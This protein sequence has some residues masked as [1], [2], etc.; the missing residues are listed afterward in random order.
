MEPKPVGTAVNYNFNSWAFRRLKSASAKPACLWQNLSLISGPHPTPYVLKCLLSRFSREDQEG[1]VLAQCVRGE[2]AAGHQGHC[3]CSFSCCLLEPVIH[4]S[5][6]ELHPVQTLWLHCHCRDVTRACFE[7]KEC[8]DDVLSLNWEGWFHWSQPS[9]LHVHF[10][11]NGE[12]QSWISGLKP[13]VQGFQAK[14]VCKFSRQ[15]VAVGTHTLN[16]QCY[17]TFFVMVEFYFKVE[18]EALVVWFWWQQSQ[19]QNSGF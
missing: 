16:T 2:L 7:A 12:D 9:G 13:T 1:R 18:Q 10:P 8:P 15:I 19:N 11:V 4:L 6:S 17:R 3:L 5:Y 14:N